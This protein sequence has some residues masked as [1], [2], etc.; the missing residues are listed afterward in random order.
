MTKVA[1][2]TGA[3]SGVGRAVAQGLDAAGYATVLVGRKQAALEETAAGLSNKTL[4]A[5][6]DV[7]DPQ[8]V[9]AV[10][11]RIAQTF[12][13]LDVLFN[14]AGMGTP[15]IPI[16]DRGA[17]EVLHVRGEA[18][19]GATAELA[20]APAG[21]RAANPAFDLTPAAL[22]T[23]IVTERGIARPGEL[24]RLYPEQAR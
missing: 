8:A 20:L 1:M 7:G 6:A 2:I 21:T 14:N 3:G 10:F 24:A 15:A 19:D 12:G 17:D 23:G 22:I 16:E 11:A 4:V 9:K 5:P 18:A 13:R